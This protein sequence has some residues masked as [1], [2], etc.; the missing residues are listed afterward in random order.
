MGRPLNDRQWC[1]K[2]RPNVFQITDQF[3]DSRHDIGLID[4]CST[5]VSGRLEILLY[6]PLSLKTLPRRH[7]SRGECF[8]YD[9]PRSV[10]DHRRG[11]NGLKESR[12]GRMARHREPALSRGI[13]LV[14]CP[15]KYRRSR[16]RALRLWPRTDGR[17][18]LT[19]NT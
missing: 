17:H 9:L 5:R 10:S 13:R 19:I 15:T 11:S 2:Y 7:R 6:F 16:C 3:P 18:A 8:S 14:R 4:Q 1:Q 12:D